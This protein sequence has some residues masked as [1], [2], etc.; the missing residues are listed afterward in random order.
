[1]SLTYLIRR[2]LLVIPTFIGIT[3]L[4][5]AIT[6]IVPGGP[7]ERILSEAQLAGSEGG[8]GSGAQSKE[9]AGASLSDEQM[10]QLKEYYGFDK[11]APLAY[12]SWLWKLVRLDLGNST[13]YYEPVWSTISERLPVS[14]YYGLISLII[15]YLISIPLGIIKAIR[16]RTA[17]DNFS[18]ILI[19][20]GYAIPPLVIAVLLQAWLGAHLE[21]FPLGGFQSEEY[22]DLSFFGK[23][24]DLVWHSFC[25]MIAYI[26]GSFA[27]MTM[28]MKNALMDNLAADYVRT[29]MA[30]G[31]SF[32]WAVLRH[33]LRNS[34]IPL[35]T[36]FG[37]NIGFFLAGSL[38]IEQVFNIDGFGLLGYES[39]LERD[40]PVVMGILAITA[41]LQLVGN[42]LSDFCV[43]LV[44][45]RVQFE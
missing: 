38:F 20:I 39:L 19:F 36:H 27:L 32:R 3:V 11:P 15:A 24:K 43:A 6:R 16:H 14:T 10:Q 37:N 5:F 21:W 29:A 35:A 41:V 44:D 1:M 7:I 40:Y 8:D 23:V 13:R 42:I 22:A 31:L 45:P 34:L 12:L 26:A 2:L 28:M 17:L 9:S 25:P 30:K 18:S 4:V 33:A